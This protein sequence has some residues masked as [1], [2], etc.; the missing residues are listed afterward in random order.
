MADFAPITIQAVDNNNVEL[1]NFSVP[2]DFEVSVKQV[3]ERAFI[4]GQTPATPDPFLYTLEYYGYSESAQFP[5]Y[6]GYEIESIGTKAN[7]QLQN[8]GQFFWELNINDVPSSDGA[9]TTFP[10]PG[11]VVLW[12][13]VP[14]PPMPHQVPGR[15]GVVHSRRVAR[16]GNA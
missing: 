16:L 4:A 12:K 8:T 9:D 2:Y 3:L 10:S 7:G 5:G 15:A 13:Y 14:V 6:L 11:S 1:F